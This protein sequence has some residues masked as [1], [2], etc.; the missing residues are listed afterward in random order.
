M[1]AESLGLAASV[2]GLLSLGLQITGGIV[3]YLDALDRR[4]EELAHLRQQ[5]DALTAILSALEIISS[6]LQVQG[7][8]LVLTTTVAQHIQSCKDGL[9]AVETLRVD[10][11]DGDTRI[12]TMRLENK[13]KRL[14]YAFNEP[15]VQQL[16]QRLQHTNGLLQLALTGLGLEISTPSTNKLASIE[17]SFQGHASKLLHIHSIVK[18]V[19]EPL[20]A[21]C[22]RLPI[23]QDSFEASS[24]LVE[25]HSG[26]IVD[27]VEESTQAI[28][29]L[30]K[31]GKL[32]KH[33]QREDRRSRPKK[34]AAA[35]ALIGPAALKRLCGS[36]QSLKQRHNPDFALHQIG[37]SSRVAMKAPSHNSQPASAAG[38]ICICPLPHRIVV[39]RG[40]QLGH[41][42]ISNESEV[43]GHWPS[44]P[45]SESANKT[46]KALSLKYTGF[47][48]I[49]QSAIHASFAWTSGAGGFSISP[50][51]T[52]YPTMDDKTDYAFR[53]IDLMGRCFHVCYSGNKEPFMTTCLR[54]LLA[55]LDT[56]KAYPAA[57]NAR[58]DNLIHCA[59]RR[60]MFAIHG[61]GSDLRGLNVFTELIQTLLS[62]GIPAFS[63]DDQGVSPLLR[64][65][66]HESAIIKDA[67]DVLVRA[68]LEGKP[69]ALD[70]SSCG[71]DDTIYVITS[72]QRNWVYNE[73]HGYAEGA[74]ALKTPW[75]AV[76]I[77]ANGWQ[78]VNAVH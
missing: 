60:L 47:A 6:R 64:V 50:N 34:S 12:W 8:S 38:R 7:Q 37:L 5:N 11:T 74:L 21:I 29:A 65:G 24:R 22:D 4:Q 59:A 49:L 78:L 70:G 14:T 30:E 54:K 19:Q 13:R 69:A 61:Q 76:L 58:G 26:R 67:I 27:V 63:Y 36:A 17:S 9:T 10:L 16:T 3:K 41:I 53:I 55:V 46:R 2:G 62:Y 51:I 75:L 71:F 73:F 20:V 31:F 23:L 52:C 33:I 77:L 66:M 68:N 72:I 48:R 28:Q 44:C 1:A 32:L 25:S 15:K 42:S 45:H 43:K 39:Q 18:A 57:V 35:I 56:R 40:I